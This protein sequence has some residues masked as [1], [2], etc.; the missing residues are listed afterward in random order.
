MLVVSMS[1]GYAIQTLAITPAIVVW[2][3]TAHA[4]YLGYSRRT[5]PKGT[6]LTVLVGEAINAYRAA[7][8]KAADSSSEDHEFVDET[9]L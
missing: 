2:L 5:V 9:V 1:P 3:H 7:R 8:E 6:D 4:F